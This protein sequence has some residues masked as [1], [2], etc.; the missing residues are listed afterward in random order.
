MLPN[1]GVFDPTTNIVTWNLGTVAPGQATITLG[2]TLEI[3]F[4]SQ[5]DIDQAVNVIEVDGDGTTGLDSDPTNNI[6]TEVDILNV[7]PDPAEI[8]RVLG[9]DGDSPNDDYR[10]R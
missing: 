3:L 5:A 9:D 10:G 4:P 1:G 6:D 2:L 7:L 8:A